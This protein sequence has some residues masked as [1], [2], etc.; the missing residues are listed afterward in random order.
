M[1]YLKDDPILM[2]T[3]KHHKEGSI[4]SIGYSKNTNNEQIGTTGSDGLIYIYN[5]NKKTNFKLVGHIGEVND[6]KFSHKN[7]FIVS[8]GKDNSIRVWQN[9]IKGESTVIKQH[10]NNVREI[11]ISCDDS[12]L[13]SCSDDKTMKVYNLVNSN[14][15]SQTIK[16]SNNWI[17]SV[18]F[19]NDGRLVCSG[20]DDKHVNIYDIETKQQVST[21]QQPSMVS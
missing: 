20:G 11:D 18:R 8:C 2:E 1:E 3:L 21:V 12:L 5:K 15:V 7:T 17:R 16:G 14:R 9:N 4:R 6:I 19:S 10:L 13:V